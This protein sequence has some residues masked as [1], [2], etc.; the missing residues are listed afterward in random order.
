MFSKQKKSIKNMS[1]VI[2][3]LLK[4]ISE[5]INTCAIDKIK[6]SKDYG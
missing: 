6:N 5:V 4:H 3:F 2:N 1:V